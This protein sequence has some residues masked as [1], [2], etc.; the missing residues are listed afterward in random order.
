MIKDS[1][2]WELA[3]AYVTGS[4]SEGELRALRSRLGTDPV[5]A[6]DFQECVNMLSSLSGAG[7]QQA[8]KGMLKDIQSQQEASFP[9]KVSR[10]I[11]LKPSQIKTA[12][13]AAGVAFLIC[14]SL[15]PLIQHSNTSHAKDYQLLVHELNNIKRSQANIDRSQKQLIQK[16]NGLNEPSIQARYSGT[17]FAL[18]ND[19]YFVTNY[20]VA[21]DADSIYIQNRNG[22]YYKAFIVTF[23][24]GSDVAILKVESKNFRF[25]KGNDVPYTFAPTK[26]GLGARVF[27][28][29]YPQDEVVYNEGYIS[30]RNGFQG[31]SIQYRLELPASPGQS[32]A[33]VLDASGN[34]IAIVTGKESETEGTTYAVSSKAIYQL[35]SS[36][37]SGDDIRLPKANKLGKMGREQQIEKLQNY[38][39]LVKIYK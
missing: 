29:G 27:T 1:N 30:S 7:R 36:L 16:I 23:D 5:F 25:S 6:A 17:G 18:T 15:I 8:F 11:N 20:H 39:C 3:E 10:T 13:I 9:A 14:V 35:L 2:N 24:E 26:K 33:P 34:V 4:L 19:G 12:A 31:D 38:T 32:G 21:R 37:P 28:L 22:D